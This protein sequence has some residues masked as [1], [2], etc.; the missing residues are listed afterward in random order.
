M[1][2][3]IL[4]VVP[5]LIIYII[6]TPFLCHYITAVTMIAIVISALLIIHVFT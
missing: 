2:M 3:P 4:S 5:L 6:L 1:L